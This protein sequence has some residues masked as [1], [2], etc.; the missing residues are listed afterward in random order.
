MQNS[1]CH[2]FRLVY[3]M[4]TTV[5]LEES[6][7]EMLR[8]RVGCLFEGRAGQTAPC[9]SSSTLFPPLRSALSVLQF[10]VHT[11][12]NLMLHYTVMTLVS[13]CRPT[14]DS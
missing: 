2:N 14:L 8:S 9:L 11:G 12:V 1:Y 4:Y 3:V 10:D 5:L 7:Q 6:E 13:P